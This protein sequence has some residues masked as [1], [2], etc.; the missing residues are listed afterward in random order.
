MI[1]GGSSSGAPRT[2]AII[3]RSGIGDLI[4]HIPYLRALAA[5]SEGGRI[6][7]IAR[8][9]SRAGEILAAE[10]CIEQVI[11]FD[12]HPRKSEARVGRH[13]GLSAQLAFARGLRTQGFE[14]AVILGARARYAL[15]AW[16]A[17]IPRRAG[18]GFSAFERLWLNQPP[19]IRPYRGPG[20][21]VYPEVTAFCLAQGYTDSPLIPKMRVLP[22]AMHTAAQVLDALPH[23]RYAFAIGASEARKHWGDVRYAELAQILIECGASVVLLGGPAEEA[24]ARAIVEQLPD[25]ARARIRISAQPSIQT[26]AALLRQCDF[27]LGND[28][29]AL[30]MAAAN[31]LPALGLFGSTP[32]LLHDPLLSGLPAHGM[33]A[34]TPADV[35]ARLTELGAP[36]LARTGEA[37]T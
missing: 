35:I 19:F 34:I 26:S 29:G 37:V 14:R 1:P 18:F 12:I 2:L 8:P 28:T 9:S 7:L 25:H 33:D 13:D 24:S 21:W 4:W 5:H 23:P 17:G 11:E 6:T 3:H 31:D 16:L 10:A 27:C 15:L 30:N 32:P 20:N 36:G 22:A